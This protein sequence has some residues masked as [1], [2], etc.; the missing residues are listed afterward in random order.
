MNSGSCVFG[1]LKKLQCSLKVLY[2]YH[3]SVYVL[4]MNNDL[5]YTPSFKSSN[6]LCI[7]GNE[8]MNVLPWPEFAYTKQPLFVFISVGQTLA[9]AFIGVS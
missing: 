1:S 4:Y 5:L 2:Y 9:Y 3:A 8:T 6:M 7:I